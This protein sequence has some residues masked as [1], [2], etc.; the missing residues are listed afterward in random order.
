M[1]LRLKRSLIPSRGEPKMFNNLTP[2]EMQILDMMAI[3]HMSVKEISDKL[4]I[5]KRTVHYHLGNIYKKRN[6]PNNSRS[7]M[8]L[9]LEY[10]QYVGSTLANKDE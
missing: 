3:Q 5:S 2:K 7:Q 10:A 4:L 8:K 1:R 6:Y 9:A